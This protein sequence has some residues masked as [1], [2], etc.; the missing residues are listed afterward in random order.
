MK[1]EERIYL[2]TGVSGQDGFYSARQFLRKGFQVFGTSRQTLSDSKPHLQ[3]LLRHPN[4][5][6]I[7][8]PE[9]TAD[10]V[11]SLIQEIQ[12]HRIVH[13][14][15][16]RDLPSNESEIAQCYF[17]NCDLTEFL[18]SSMAECAPRARLV[19][20]SSAEIFGKRH[21]SVLDEA[22]PIKPENQYAISK[23][24]GMEIVNHYRTVRGVFAVAAIC[25]NHDSCLS[26]ATHLVRLVPKKLLALKQGKANV[27]RFYNTAVR[28]D[29]SHAKDFAAAFD[30]MLEQDAPDDFLVASGKSTTLLEYIELACDVLGIRSQ[31]SLVFEERED[32][33][34]YDRIACSNR[35]QQRLGWKPTITL[36]QLCRQMIRLE[37]R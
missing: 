33:E 36:R 34:S 1:P 2:V 5:R 10:R 25:F 37:C 35:I 23:V 26:P 8:V 13:C 14:A 30:L 6:F 28:R 29:W 31:D 9:Y 4:F 18:L 17:T 27:I 16:F 20:I 7:S 19:F 24:H 12:P 15:G 11:R 32:E 22:T 21:N 3:L